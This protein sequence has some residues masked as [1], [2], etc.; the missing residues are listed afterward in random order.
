MCARLAKYLPGTLLS[1]TLLLV[2]LAGAACSGSDPVAATSPTAAPQV[3]L[4]AEPSIVRPD[5]LPP[6]AA[7]HDHPGFRTRFVVFVGGFGGV[8]MDGLQAS[9]VDAF[10][11][12]VM[13]GVIASGVFGG[14]TSTTSGVPV[15]LPTSGPIPFPMTGP[16]PIPDGATRQVPVTLEF[17]CH[18][19][20][21]G[22]IVVTART[23]DGRGRSWDQ[24]L[25][26]AVEE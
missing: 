23:R 5:F 3:S 24:R 17:G 8:T 14:A 26:V 11:V 7:C 22:T 9:F 18:V 21:H 16:V 4:K 25:A 20:P 15:P 6:S 13:P 1:G 2:V 19:R 12:S 10:G